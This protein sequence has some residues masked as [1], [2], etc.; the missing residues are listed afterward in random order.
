MRV[1]ECNVLLL[2]SRILFV[3]SASIEVKMHYIAEVVKL[4]YT[5]P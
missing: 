1:R 3:N 2:L 4:V 5:L